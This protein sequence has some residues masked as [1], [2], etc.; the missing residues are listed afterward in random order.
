MLVA[1]RSGSPRRTVPRRATT[2]T[3]RRT[4]LPAAF[5]LS[6]VGAC[7]LVPSDPEPPPVGLRLDD[8]VLT[9]LIPRCP[10]EQVV[11]A[12]VETQAADGS[13][14]PVWH[15]T[16]FGGDAADG[17]ELAEGAWEHTE[18][19]YADPDGLVGIAVDTSHA[20]YGA[21][22]VDLDD[23]RGLPPGEYSVDSG[24]GDA[25]EYARLVA[26]FPCPGPGS[27]TSAPTR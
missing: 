20:L 24:V 26:D 18:G 12:R 14:Q 19:D 10:G 22:R 15:A 11:A 27:D 4:V 1:A 9:V 7:G 17:V 25:Q 8:D 2:A 21:G 3:L 5:V 23:L 13:W 16:T 6:V